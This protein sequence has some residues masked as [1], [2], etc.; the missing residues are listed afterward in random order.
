MKQKDQ[1]IQAVRES[2]VK[3]APLCRKVGVSVQTYKNFI[4]NDIGL[5]TKHL[6]RFA[7]VL[8]YDINW[9]KK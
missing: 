7:E 1:L 9:I 4:K 3:I 5:S 8:G 2:G 6:E